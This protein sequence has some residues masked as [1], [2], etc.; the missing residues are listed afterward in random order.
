MP[1]LLDRYLA[2]EFEPVWNEMHALGAR[3]REPA[4][5]EDA[6]MV[7]RET[8][9]RARLNFETIIQRLDQIGYRFDDARNRA[10]DAEV[11]AEAL[12]NFVDSIEPQARAAVE[13]APMGGEALKGMKKLLG[14]MLSSRK[15]LDQTRAQARQRPKPPVVR[16]HVEDASIYQRASKD[17]ARQVAAFEKKL[18][19]PFPLSLAAWYEQ[20]EAI[21]LMGSH[22]VICPKSP[23][24]LAGGQILMVGSA[25]GPPPE[26][27]AAGPA[28]MAADPFATY[29]LDL[30]ALKDFQ[31]SADPARRRATAERKLREFDEMMERTRATTGKQFP[32]AWAGIQERMAPMRAQHEAELRDAEKPL[33]FHL[34][35]GPDDIA[36][37]G[38]SGDSYY[39]QLPD[40]SADFRVQGAADGL[41]FVQYLRR[42]FACGGFPGWHGRADQ[43][44]EIR[45]LAEGLLPL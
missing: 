28:T 25:F 45:A 27:P 4:I 42:T 10:E 38:E 35:L 23:A 3:V 44:A 6:L 17:A 19:G 12:G 31:R 21:S 16:N 15:I 7:A 24:P 37:A 36:K 32:N 2:G 33:D 26:R 13:N 34:P 9:R 8:V 39:V 18:G 41:R 1:A 5:Y 11:D 40:P 43:P 20:I 29:P 22:P 30:D 14:A